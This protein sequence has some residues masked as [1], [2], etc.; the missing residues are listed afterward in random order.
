[1]FVFIAG[2][3]ASHCQRPRCERGR[4]INIVINEKL[5]GEKGKWK[6]IG[7]GKRKRKGKGENKRAMRV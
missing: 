1:M 3:I 2:N 6:G 7:R 4:E 5:G